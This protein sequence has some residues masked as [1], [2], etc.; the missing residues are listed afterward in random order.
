MTFILI[1][2]TLVLIFIIT[3]L[4]FVSINKH[5]KNSDNHHIHVKPDDH[6]I[7]NCPVVLDKTKLAKCD[8]SDPNSCED[9]KNDFYS[10]INVTKDNPYIIKDVDGKNVNIPEGSWCLPLVKKSNIECNQFT[11]YPILIKKSEKEMGWHCQ[12][13][14]PNLFENKKGVN[15]DCTKEIACNT[16]DNFGTLVC[17]KDK[18]FCKE[19]EKW[20]DNP[21]WDPKYGVCDC[22]KGKYN[23][24]FNQDN[25]NINMHCQTDPCYPGELIT[26]DK[27]NKVC[28][29]PESIKD[30][31][32]NIISY[33]RSPDDIPVSDRK[34]TDTLKCL[35]DPCNPGGKYNKDKEICECNIDKNYI[36]KQDSNSRI[37]SI[38]INSCST[39]N[40]PCY[41]SERNKITGTCKVEKKSSTSGVTNVDDNYE[42]VCL[43][44]NR[45]Y[46]DSS[47]N[48]KDCAKYVLEKDE[49][50]LL[51][52]V[53]NSPIAPYC[54]P[55]LYCK[56]YF[57]PFGKGNYS[58]C[59]KK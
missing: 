46:M 49:T 55:G 10:C 31:D 17:P 39:K 24:I 59:E 37:K 44:C 33:I 23:I 7:R 58:K 47:K 5:S 43:N 25:N 14:Y 41:D 3:V 34:N 27:G 48:A 42:T 38:C 32:G 50:C 19:G 1:F 29:C 12:C 40:N 16:N 4:V 56:K 18:D 20:T 36:P 57:K 22:I 9:C 52:S 28:K 13:R 2:I 8:S 11:G 30:K 51:N 54:R 15:T 45:N 35:L 26:D 53:D 6:T 21:T